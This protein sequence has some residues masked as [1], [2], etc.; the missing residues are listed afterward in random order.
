MM[1]LNE[2]QQQRLAKLER[3]RAAGI[4]PYPARSARTTLI[5]DALASFDTLADAATPM[6][7]AGRIVGARRVMGKLAFAHIEDESAK[8]QL[9]IS[10]ADLGDEWFNRFRDDLDTFDIIEATG[11]LRRT[12]SGEQSLFVTAIIMLAKALNHWL[13]LGRFGLPKS[14]NYA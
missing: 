1:E 10:R 13:Y 11:T 2:L 6:T 4:D 14:P 9:W 7:I 5:A 3:L 12:K 8:I